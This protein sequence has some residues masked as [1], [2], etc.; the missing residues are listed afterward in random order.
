MGLG[1]FVE[2]NVLGYSGN[3]VIF[4]DLCSGLFLFLSFFVVDCI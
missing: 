1:G 4:V 3:G 2:G